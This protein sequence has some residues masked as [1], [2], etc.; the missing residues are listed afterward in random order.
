MR[1][2]KWFIRI[3]DVFTMW[4]IAGLA[5]ALVVGRIIQAAKIREG[6]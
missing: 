2:E 4:L 5:V 1:F 6:R 3:G